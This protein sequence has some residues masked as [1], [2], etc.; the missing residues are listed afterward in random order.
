MTI[1]YIAV[2]GSSVV[3]LG[4]GP[5]LL[6]SAGFSTLALVWT[7]STLFGLGLANPTELVVTRRLSAGEPHALHPFRWFSLWSVLSILAVLLGGG[8]L[9]A[10]RNGVGL[11]WGTILAVTG[12]VAATWVRGSLA[13]GGHLTRYG[14]VLVVEAASRIGLVAVALLVPSW[15]GAALAAAV[16]VPLLLAAG[17]G[18]LLR[19]PGRSV[20]VPRSEDHAG[21]HLHFGVV[22]VA[23][24]ACLNGPALLLDWQVGYATPALVG[25]FVA[26]STVLRAPSLLVGGLSTQALVSLSRSWSDGDWETYSA[27]TRT[28]AVRWARLV[29]PATCLVLLLS[30]WLLP[31]YYGS[32]VGLSPAVV[33][34]LALS[35]VLATGAAVG[36]GPLFAAGRGRTA[37]MA[38]AAGAAV[39]SVVVVASSGST[40]WLVIGLVSGP[41]VA[42]VLVV[43]G[44]VAALRAANPSSV[45]A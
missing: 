39:T 2:A 22:S 5:R 23:Y 8:S 20:V 41:L 28:L 12:W 14:A 31:L 35:T 16:G 13:G 1:G 25:A 29:L 9:H 21:E 10:A 27:G 24:Q 37:A 45:A 43:L 15:A 11:T 18:L 44:V 36:T 40:T 34:G 6:G 7:L 19:R 3:L 32:A 38:W 42:A 33:V 26:V 30:P 4:A 17:A